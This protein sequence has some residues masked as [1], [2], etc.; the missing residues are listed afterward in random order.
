MA[1]SNTSNHVFNGVPDE[2]ARGVRAARRLRIGIITG[3]GPEAGLDL[4]QKLLAENRKLIGGTFRGDL[5]A[6]AV[7]ILSEPDLG[8]SIE[9]SENEDIV[10]ACL[11]QS[12][13]AVAEHVDVYTIACNTLHYFEDRLAAMKLGARFISFADTA[14][15]H[16]RLQRV[17]SVALL[18]WY[19]VMELGCWSP[20]ARL[21][22]HVT[23]EVP[24]EPEQVCQLIRDIKAFG[25]QAELTHRLDT[26][27]DACRAE[28]VLLAC[29]ELSLV[30]QCRADGRVTDLTGLVA[31][32]LARLSLGNGD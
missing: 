19:P 2:A 32:R 30:N 12:A 10:W 8:L 31:R 23:V 13:I 22:A 7:T 11:K 24:P 21:A 20:Y 14:M 9:L 29:T 26:I 17:R 18:G 25:P 15:D 6:P 3:S 1:M 4:W 5:D 27:V 28:L 16:I